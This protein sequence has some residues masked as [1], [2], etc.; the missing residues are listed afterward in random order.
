MSWV[1]LVLYDR[2][3]PAPDLMGPEGVA[4]A[5]AYYRV[6][7]AL[8]KDK[9]PVV[10]KSCRGCGGTG[11]VRARRWGDPDMD[12]PDCGGTGTVMAAC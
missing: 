12:C 5:D 10:P 7:D 8:L 6:N 4:L 11:K 2:P 3:P 9:A 1:P